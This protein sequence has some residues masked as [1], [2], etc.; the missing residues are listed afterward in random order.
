MANSVDANAYRQLIEAQ[1]FTAFID[2]RAYTLSGRILAQRSLPQRRIDDD[3]RAESQREP[4]CL[5]I[6]EISTDLRQVRPVDGAGMQI[7]P[8]IRL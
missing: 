3:R 7:D 4:A 1:R 6:V 8:E 2:D 5:R